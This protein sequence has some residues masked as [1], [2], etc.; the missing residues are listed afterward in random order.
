MSGEAPGVVALE[1]EP[2]TD[3]RV[4]ASLPEL[5][6]TV[7]SAGSIGEGGTLVLGVFVFPLPLPL[8]MTGS[9]S[10]S[11]VSAAGGAGSETAGGVGCEITGGRGWEMTGGGGWEMAGGAGSGQEGGW[12]IEVEILEAV[13]VLRSRETVLVTTVETLDAVDTVRSRTLSWMLRSVSVGGAGWE[14]DVVLFL[15]PRSAGMG[16]GD[17][18]GATA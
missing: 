5:L 11:R 17:V 3:V 16:A 18:A 4:S 14:L 1:A 15:D 12:E 13:E 8:T 7:V 9:G 6:P 2:Q 10:N